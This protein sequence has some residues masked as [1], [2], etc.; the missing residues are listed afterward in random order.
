MIEVKNI[1]F[2]TPARIS[3]LVDGKELSVIAGVDIVNRKVYVGD[4]ESEFGDSVFFYLD[5]IN[6]LPD[7]FFAAPPEVVAEAAQAEQDVE[8]ISKQATGE[9]HG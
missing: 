8:Q 2:L 6:S 4:T 9:M 5:E 7:D 3:L 1:E